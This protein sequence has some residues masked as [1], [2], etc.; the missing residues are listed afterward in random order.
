MMR[1]RR[2]IA[3]IIGL[4]GF[5]APSM[6]GQSTAAPELTR[7]ALE[8]WLDEYMT[9]EQAEKKTAGAVV[10]VVKNGEVLLEK[11][12]G[13]ADLARHIPVDPERT[14]FRAGSVS[15]LFTWTAV[16][17]QVEQ[18][19]IDLDRDVNAYLDFKIPPREGKP[20]T[21]RN[22][23][24]HTPG[25]EDWAK[26]L[27]SSNPKGV[28]SLAT[29]IKRWVPGRI[30][31]PGTM[32]AY[33]NY[34]TALAAYIVTRVFGLPFDDYMDRNIFGRLGMAHS[35]FRQ[36]LPEHLRADVTQSYGGLPGPVKPYEMLA[37]P[38]AGSLSA[39]GADMAKF[40]IAHL[41]GGRYGGAQL[42]R[43]ETVGMMHDTPLTILPPLNRMLLGFYEKN[44][45]GRRIIGHDGDTQFNHALLRL[46]LDDHV[47]V[48][49]AVNTA[50][51][52]KLRSD[53]FTAFIN[54]FF[55][56]PDSRSA[57]ETVDPK[58]AAQHAR[59]IAGGYDNSKTWRFNFPHIIVLLAQERVV[60]NAD[61]SISIEGEPDKWR[62][63]QPFVWRKE[64]STER[65]AA[66]I[67][68]GKVV[69]FSYDELSPFMMFNRTSFWESAEW[70]LPLLKISV[71]VLL[72]A[73]LLWP[74]A[75][76]VRRVR[77]KTLPAHGDTA[78]AFHLMG[79]AALASVL[80]AYAW[81]SLLSMMLADYT[82]ISS[83][84]DGRIWFLH[85]AT[86]VVCVGAGLIA[87][88]NAW[89][90]WANK[91]SWFARAWSAVLVIACLTTFW[92]AFTFKLIAFSVN[93]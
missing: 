56:A 90:A 52:Y 45:N 41:E 50:D 17:Q 32:P 20:I 9:R 62:E 47:G 29:F 31:V 40:M 46:V 75:W 44:R 72:I 8:T 91:R 60:A 76:I 33:S 87:I 68:N 58:T 27:W 21:M 34:G 61:G 22:L 5:A 12:Y 2:A 67:E 10:V 54:H 13:F 55:P 49:I 59:M 35:S 63:F 88:W 93:Y 36:P 14:L 37:L 23:M 71:A 81:F 38:P 80:I 70:L 39:T 74:V 83:A 26:D 89:L 42:L 53:L 18:G 48:Y 69:R 73:V 77:A 24:T 79:A 51:G 64:G 4:I 11:G 3:I 84:L 7:G 92:V 28:A 43:P 6:N 19:K 25:F 30:Y 1:T 66:K 86:A 16:M 15:K 57:D 85:I 82:T 65:L 78:V